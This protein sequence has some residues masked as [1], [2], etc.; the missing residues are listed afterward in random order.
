[1]TKILYLKAKL[2]LEEFIVK[3]ILVFSDFLV[4]RLAS[5]ETALAYSGEICRNSQLRNA[6]TIFLVPFRLRSIFQ[7]QNDGKRNIKMLHVSVPIVFK[8][9]I[10]NEMEN[11]PVIDQFNILNVM[12][13][14]H[15]LKI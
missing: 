9:K 13:G 6:G 11:E 5:F 2:V 3:S 14:S 8:S 4:S 15:G 7:H 12:K 10:L 1:M